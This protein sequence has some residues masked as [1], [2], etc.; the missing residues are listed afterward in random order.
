MESFEL[1]SVE[2]LQDLLAGVIT[3]LPTK[4]PGRGRILNPTEEVI[5]RLSGVPGVR[6][7]GQDWLVPYNLLLLG[8]RPATL[9]EYSP[10]S[11]AAAPSGLPLKDYQRRSVTFLRQIDRESA[12][13]ILAADCGLG[14]S[15]ISL[16]ASWLD[17]YLHR[18]GLIIGPLGARGTWCASDG[19]PAKHYGL[20]VTALDGTDPDYYVFKTAQPSWFFIHYDILK[21]WQSTIFSDLKPKCLIIDECLPP[22]A[23]VLTSSGLRR[24]ADVVDAGMPTTVLSRNLKTGNVEWK[25]TLR[26]IRNVARGPLVTITCELGKLECTVNHK[27]WTEE[28][29]YVQADQLRPGETLCLVPE[30]ICPDRQSTIRTGSQEVLQSAVRQKSQ[31]DYP[32]CASGEAGPEAQVCTNCVRDMPVPLR[33]VGGAGC[34]SEA[35]PAILLSALHGSLEEQTSSRGSIVEALNANRAESQN[36]Q[37]G[38]SNIPANACV[39]SYEGPRCPGAG[40]QSPQ[41]VRSL[42]EVARGERQAAAGGASGSACGLGHRLGSGV[43]CN[44]YGRTTDQ[45]ARSLLLQDRHSQEYCQASNRD[46]RG[47]AQFSEEKRAGQQKRPGV[48]RTRVVSITIQECRSADTATGGAAEDRCGYVYNLEVADNHNY[49]ADGILVSNCHSVMN[50]SSARWGATFGVAGAAT[51]ER[52]IGLT[53]TP[54]PKTRLDLFGQLAVVQPHQWDE[55]TGKHYSFGIRYLAGH[56]MTTEGNTEGKS[57]WVFDGHSNTAELRAR[58]AGVYLRYTKADVPGELPGLVRHRIDVELPPEI[59]AEYNFAKNN[60]LK[61][62]AS[63]GKRRAPETFEIAGT[64]YTLNPDDPKATQLVTTSALKSILDRGKVPQALGL[65]KQLASRHERIVVFT[66][67]RE[68]AKELCRDLNAARAAN[69]QAI[70]EVFGPIDGTDKWEKRIEE[71]QAFAQSDWAVFV[72][73]RGSVGIAINDLSCADAC[74]QITP[75]WSPDGNLQAESRLHREGARA[76]E[77]HSYYM[78]A[79]KTLDDRVLELL[80]A[81]SEEAKAVA[82]DDAGGLH[83]VA[84]LDPTYSDESRWSLDE[85]CAMLANVESD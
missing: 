78:L 62:Q 64:T 35:A 61:W 81:K 5:S 17:G 18:P 14:K 60:V 34:Q 69:I 83:L 53:G 15:I 13:G 2:R 84:D 70:P 48:A 47:V 36:R 50:S 11:V 71:A 4:Y 73:T 63:K 26:L 16:Q 41:T 72:A 32:S 46:R 66:W 59:R 65:I 3:E 10:D 85:I 27:V 68:S 8:A 45:D 54:I 38:S 76:P 33:A 30:V 56:R 9:L 7:L 79:P 6:Q 49:F 77:I 55:S 44:Y 24:I 51:I 58:L 75:D 19:D 43:S 39:Q 74:L 42:P 52:R 25:R 37:E 57:W 80:R 82:P 29:G 1:N 12:G 28:R 31:C 40:K 23:A 20:H 22:D 67:R 21:A